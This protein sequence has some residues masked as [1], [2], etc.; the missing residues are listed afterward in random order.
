MISLNIYQSHLVV[1]GYRATLGI[2]W[3]GEG[4]P[5]QR[6]EISLFRTACSES[7]VAARR[8]ILTEYHT[9][10]QTAD[11]IFKHVRFA[12]VGGNTQ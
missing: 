3:G 12:E 9:L 11:S 1:A 8:I 5:T 2:Y 7:K 10:D 6:K 4:S